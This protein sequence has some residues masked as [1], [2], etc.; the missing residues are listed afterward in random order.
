MRKK[1][2]G[3]AVV[4]VTSRPTQ[5]NELGEMDFDVVVEIAG[6]SAEQVG[7]F[8]GKYF[9]LKPE[10]M[11][12]ALEHI[13]NNANLLSIAHI[14][15]LCY[16]MCWCLEWQIESK[17]EGDLPITITDLYSEVVEIF[18]MKLN[19]Q[20]EYRAKPIP[21]QHK[22]PPAIENTMVKLSKLAAETMMEKK[23][24]FEE[25]DFEKFYVASHEIENLKASGLITCGPGI[26]K[27]AFK[28]TRYFC[29]SHLTLHEYFA[30]ADFVKNS[31]I[32]PLQVSNSH[33][34]GKR[35][36][37]RDS[38]FYSKVSNNHNK[39]KRG[40]CRD[41]RFYSK[42]SNSH[43]KGKRGYC[44]DSRFYSKVSNNHNKGKRS[45]CRDSQVYSKDSNSH[46]K[47]KRGYCRDSQVYS[48]V[49]NNHNKGKRSYYRDSQVYSKVSNNHNKGKRSYCRDSQFYSNVSNSHNKG[50][51]S[52]C[53]DSQ[54]YSKVSNS[55][56]KGKRS[57]CRDSKVMSNNHKKGNWSYWRVRIRY[58]K[59]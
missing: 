14:P 5:A 42:V 29:F 3:G 2:F 6:F 52:Y 21:Q 1:I 31:R 32:P 13:M 50:K 37:C 57:Y 15:M 41:S 20:S 54:V 23:L 59:H 38:R 51:R 40:Y 26:R 48:K 46:N 35:G 43:N 39:D 30:A 19:S 45:Y 53:R 28:I 56:N 16:L 11:N 9:R 47:G 8:I 34:K 25:D 36:Y 49:S 17:P 44:R 55:H 7:E 27:T 33:N 58:K 12:G 10:M 22:V 24:I 4:M 18:E